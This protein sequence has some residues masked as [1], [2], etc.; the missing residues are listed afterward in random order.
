MVRNSEFKNRCTVTVAVRSVISKPSPR[1]H[2]KITAF[3]R[4]WIRAQRATLDGKRIRTKSTALNCVW[5][6]PERA[7]LN[8]V[9]VSPER[10]AL[11]CVWVSPERAA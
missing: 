5:V 4:K 11:N 2:Y 7:A 10:A 1:I 6:S 8:C 3:N 9:W